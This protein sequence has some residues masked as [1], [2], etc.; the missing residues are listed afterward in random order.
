VHQLRHL[1]LV[2]K[3]SECNR[4]GSARAA[5]K[6]VQLHHFRFAGCSNHRH[7]IIRHAHHGAGQQPASSQL[8][9]RHT[10]AVAPLQRQVVHGNALAFAAGSH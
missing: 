1:L 6:F 8:E 3:Q 4:A 7:I 2:P 9:R 10:F 5:R